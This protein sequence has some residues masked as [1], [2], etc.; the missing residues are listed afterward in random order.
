MKQ[1][2]IRLQLVWVSIL[3]LL[4]FGMMMS[5]VNRFNQRWDFTEEQLYSLSPSTVELLNI[6]KPAKVKVNAFY[7]QDDPARGNFEIF[8]KQC[9]LHNVNFEYH[10]HDPDRSPSLAKRYKVDEFYTV[11]I[12]YEGRQERI[13][14]PTEENFTNAL[15]RISNPKVFNICFTT[16]HGENPLNSD[17]RNG[18]QYLKHGL[19]SQNYKI[20]EIILFRDKVPTFCD[21]VAVAGPHRDLDREELKLLK[22]SFNRGRGLLFLLDPMDPGTGVSFRDFMKP[23]GVALG[24]DVI[25]DK[26]SR[27]VGGDFLIPLVS[28]YVTQHPITKTFNEPTFYPVA[29]SVQPSTDEIEGIEVVPLALSGSGSWAETNLG[30]LENGQ[31]AFEADSDVTGP[32]CLAVAVEKKPGE[33][34]LESMGGRMVVVGDSDFSTNAYSGLSGNRDVLINM[35]QWLTKDDRFI[36]IHARNPNF[37]PLFLNKMQRMVML[38]SL[39]FGLPLII[40]IFGASRVI[41]RKR[42]V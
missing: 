4:T 28:Q 35:I 3:L 9:K 32:I 21:V 15:L 38:G 34:E 20:H 24:E 13:I 39:V 27:L 36:Q 11:V 26:M 16:G 2:L 14:N 18:L 23:Y 17:A 6:L 7:P 29:R 5:I 33:N 8:L 30:A 12:E 41:L 25:V 40:F 37:K 10:F 42:S 22:D 1:L 19:E 31:A